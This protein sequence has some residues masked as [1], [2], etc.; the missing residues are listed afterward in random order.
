MLNKYFLNWV[1]WTAGVKTTAKCF[2][3]N[4]F[5]RR[6][7]PPGYYTIL[8]FISLLRVTA[9]L[10][11]MVPVGKSGANQQK[12]CRAQLHYL[13][14]PN[15]VSWGMNILPGWVLSICEMMPGLLSLCPRPR[16]K[17][18]LPATPLALQWSEMLPWEGAVDMRFAPG[19]VGGHWTRWKNSHRWGL[20][21]ENS[22]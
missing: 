7:S 16:L 8:F 9:N 1:K 19:G 17:P 6:C 11:P 12:G 10:S 4:S 20:L 14:A 2:W 21:S 5:T 18:P 3:L 13:L 22:F 15:R